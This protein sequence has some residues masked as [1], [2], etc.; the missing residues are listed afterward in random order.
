[1]SCCGKKIIDTLAESQPAK[2]KRNTDKIKRIVAGNWNLVLR[3]LKEV[4][5]E[6]SDQYHAR[7][8]LCRACQFHTWLTWH[9]FYR[10]I[11]DKG[12]LIKFM[13]EIASLES[14]PL[15]PKQAYAPKRKLFCRVCKCFLMAK[16][17]SED[18]AC[19]HNKWNID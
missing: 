5:D 3:Q 18:E 19:P 6:K 15:L 7:L 12:G 1:M 10:Y 17:A 2:K 11:N 13:K 16:A 8:G 14:W 9:E 4:P